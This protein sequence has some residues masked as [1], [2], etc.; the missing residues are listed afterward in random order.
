MRASTA[1]GERLPVG[2][3]SISLNAAWMA[4]PMYGTSSDDTRIA[5]L[6]AS[7]LP[8][9]SARSAGEQGRFS[10]AMSLISESL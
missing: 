5:M 7:R 4:V 9:H 10:R 6:K 8:Y 2:F 3:S 1:V